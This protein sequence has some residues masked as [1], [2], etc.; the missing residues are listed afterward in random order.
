VRK[1]SPKGAN[2]E[3]SISVAVTEIDA[4]NS[5]LR[6]TVDLPFV[7]A[8]QARSN[9]LDFN[10]LVNSKQPPLNR[11]KLLIVPLRCDSIESRGTKL[12]I[13]RGIVE[14]GASHIGAAG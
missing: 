6:R 10:D 3:A 11:E 7:S 8:F 2:A 5:T 4:L 13:A 14:V 9:L 1:S 12:R